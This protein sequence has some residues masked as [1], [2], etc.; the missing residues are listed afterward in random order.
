MQLARRTA[1]ALP[2]AVAAAVYL[3][4]WIEPLAWRKQLVGLLVLVLLIEFL[5]VQAGPFIGSVIYGGKMGLD[6]RQRLRIAGGLGGVY[7]LLAGLGAAAF[8]AWFPLWI[9]AWLLGVKLF[10]ALLGRDPKAEGREREMTFWIL[11][12]TYYFVAIFATMFLPVP[13]LGITEDGA[14]YGLRGQY[15][16]AN[17]PYQPIAAGFLY[18]AALALTRFS[19]RGGNLGLSA[20]GEPPAPGPD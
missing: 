3:W 11:S 7:L 19:G 1:I 9:F 17:F 4:C 5:A 2:D 18:F 16:W 13:M 20:S 12:V 14:V 6:R 10:V 8:D 15:E